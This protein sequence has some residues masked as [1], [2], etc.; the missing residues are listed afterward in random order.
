MYVKEP[1]DRLDI[2]RDCQG[3]KSEWKQE[4]RMFK[5]PHNPRTVGDGPSFIEEESHDT[6][7]KYRA[8]RYIC[9]TP[10]GNILCV[11]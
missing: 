10:I 3:E 1:H 5:I 4:C 9:E 8:G 7:V 2:E 6:D 11:R